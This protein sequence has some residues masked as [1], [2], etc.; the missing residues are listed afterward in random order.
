[1]ANSIP[2]PC[3]THLKMTTI[4]GG[5]GTKSRFISSSDIWCIN[6]FW[7]NKQFVAQ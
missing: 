4:K 5:R 1:M 2:M 3:E 6:K 7:T